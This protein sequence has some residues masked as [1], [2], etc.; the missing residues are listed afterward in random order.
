MVMRA[1]TVACGLLLSLAA[2]HAPSQVSAAPQQENPPDQFYAGIVT[3]STPEQ[4]TVSRPQ[5]GKT[6]SRT[7]KLTPDTKVEGSLS[8]D[9]R[10]TVRYISTEDGDV[11]ILVLVRTFP[12]KK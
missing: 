7:F 2:F 3:V 12:S 6:E 11:A 9:M 10:V 5:Q 8:T 1:F 4:I